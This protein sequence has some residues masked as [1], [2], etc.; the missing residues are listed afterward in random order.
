MVPLPTELI[1]DGRILY[2]NLAKA[3]IEPEWLDQQLKNAN[4][5]T[6]EN[7]L[8]AE[9]QPNGTLYIDNKAID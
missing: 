3:N 9:V 8:Y 1:S 6:L 7:V 2:Q 4:I 5:H